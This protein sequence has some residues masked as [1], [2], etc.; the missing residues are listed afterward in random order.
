MKRTRQVLSDLF[1]DPGNVDLLLLTHTHSDHVSYYPLRVFAEYGHAVRLHEDC[2]E[3]LKT[4]H[5]NGYGFKGLNIKPF[6]NR[7]FSAGEFSIKPF[8]LVHNP[9]Y[10]TYGY[11]VYYEDK[12]IVIATDFC[13]WDDVFESFLDADFIFVE[14]NHDLELLRR[15]FNP[16]SRFHMPNPQTAELLLNV[17]AESKKPPQTVMLGHISSQRNEPA[18]ALGETAGAFE[19]A[20]RPIDFKLLAAPLREYGEI[21]MIS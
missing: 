5:F 10:P 15:Y 16:N 11:Q 9:Y 12:K 3:Q 6:K 2:V 8:E 14:S 4:K 21:V 13:E 18:L 17:V 1:G 20:G 19:R 7:R